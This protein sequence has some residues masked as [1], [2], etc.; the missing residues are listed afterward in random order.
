MS[1]LFTFLRENP[2]GDYP[3]T[4]MEGRVLRSGQLLSSQR[5]EHEARR[6]V[7]SIR[8]RGGASNV[9]PVRVKRRPEG[10]GP[11]AK[12]VCSEA[13][14]LFSIGP[15]KWMTATATAA[16]RRPART[17]ASALP[18]RGDEGRRSPLLTAVGHRLQLGGATSCA[19]CQ[20]RRDPSETCLHA[21]SAPR[22][23]QRRRSVV[24]PTSIARSGAWLSHERLLP[25]A[26]RECRAERK[27]PSESAP[28]VPA[29]E[30]AAGIPARHVP[31]GV[32]AAPTGPGNEPRQTKSS[33]FRPTVNMITRFQVP[34]DVPARW[35]HPAPTRS[36]ARLQ[37]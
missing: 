35:P 21:R 37:N 27:C 13:K 12:V 14:G 33:S 20:R 10:C 4:R 17:R 19:D 18:R 2:I 3:E 30:K 16:A 11:M 26:V 7:S 24:A 15:G 29:P 5:I 25:V 28:L 8:G 6:C 34:V 32:R 36:D 22:A 9:M 23:R 1:I 31:G